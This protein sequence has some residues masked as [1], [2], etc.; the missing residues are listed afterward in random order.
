P[1]ITNIA[2]QSTNEDTT[3]AISFTVGDVETSTSRLGLSVVSS[4]NTS[5]LPTNR[6]VFGGSD[7]SRTMSMSPVANKYGYSD[8][9]IRVKDSHGATR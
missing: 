4:S 5:L 2:N 6:I 1:T 7:A 8:I 9:R 3:K